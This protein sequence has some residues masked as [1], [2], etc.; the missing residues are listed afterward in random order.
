MKR[1]SLAVQWLRLCVSKAGG[2]GSIPSQGTKIPHAAGVWP[3]KKK[4]KRSSGHKLGVKAMD[5][6]RLRGR[7][8]EPG[9]RWLFIPS[10]NSIR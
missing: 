8:E 7:G 9:F 10:T 2:V 3:K 6:G 4:K 1:T 5:C